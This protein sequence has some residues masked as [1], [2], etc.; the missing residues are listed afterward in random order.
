MGPTL[1]S[2][3]LSTLA[4]I[5]SHEHQHR[6]WLLQSLK[7]DVGPSRSPGSHI[8]HHGLGDKETT[9]LSLLLISFI[10]SDMRLPAGHEALLSLSP[11][12]LLAIVLPLQGLVGWCFL[13]RA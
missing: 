8:N 12:S 9:H 1:Y 13:L 3:I 5:G 11:L 10:S 2:P 7:P 6:L 4:G